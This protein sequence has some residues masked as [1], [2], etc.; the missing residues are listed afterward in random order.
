MD[1]DY[2]YAGGA[3][4]LDGYGWRVPFLWNYLD[5]PTG[6][7]VQGYSYWMPLASLLSAAGLL[8]GRDFTF[9]RLPFWLLA[10]L[11]PP[12]TLRLAWELYGNR[13]MAVLSAVLALFPVYYLAYLPTTDVFAVLMLLGAGIFLLVMRPQISLPGW[14]LLGIMSGLMH[15]A[16]ADGILWLAGILFLACFPVLSDILSKKPIALQ[17]GLRV[18]AA[19]LAVLGGYLLIMGPWYFRNLETWGWFFPPGSG[20]T[21][22]LTRY[23][24]TFVFPA[25]ILSPERWLAAGIGAAFQA[26]FSALWTNLQTLLAVQGGILL[27]PFALAG[28][29]HLRNNRAMR[30]AVGMW[31]CVFAFMTLVFP[32]AGTNGAFFH[33][34]AAFQP[35]LWAAAPKGVEMAV[36]W[37]SEKRHWQKGARVLAFVN[38]LLVTASI[39]LTGLVYLQRVVGIEVGGLAW[40][41]SAARYLEVEERLVKYGATPCQVVMIN[42]PPGYYAHTGRA[43]VVIPFGDEAMLLAAAREFNA[44][45]LIID[46]NNA[47]HLSRLVQNAAD[48]P[49]L[50]YL[51]ETEGAQIYAFEFP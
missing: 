28:L 8:L 47:G 43:G 13:R 6:L 39:L 17:G 24:D 21:L 36:G 2:Y 18:L 11:V 42:D 34:S 4:I 30:L 20:R 33:S 44:D 51:G 12:N 31:M 27:L 5:G 9:A 35:M 45:Y 10:A 7:P 15:L 25:E 3:I 19:L 29:W 26:R 46:E 1:A 50:S 14:F 22:W 37:L 40:N 23:E 49:G 38:I 41:A 16:R 48:Y 32:F